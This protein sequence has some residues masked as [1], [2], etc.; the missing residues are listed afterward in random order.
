MGKSIQYTTIDRV[1]STIHRQLKGTEI[2]ESDAIEWVGDALD[3]LKVYNTSEEVVTF[4]EVKNFEIDIPEGFQM[5]LQVARNNDWTFEEKNNCVIPTTLETIETEEEEEETD[6]CSEEAYKPFFDMQ[7][8]YIPWTTSNCYKE[9]FTPIRLANH[10]FF[11]SIVCKER[12]YNDV[13]QNSEDEYTIVGTV[14]RKLRFSFQEGYVAL[15]YLRTPIDDITKL[16]LIPDSISYITAITYY[17]K[18]KMAEVLAWNGRDGFEGKADKAESKWLKYA[19]QG[20]NFMKMPKGLDEHQNHLERSHYLIP[21]H[22][23]YYGF[24]GEL[25]RKEDRGFNHPNRN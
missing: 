14:N 24:F 7:W 3:F 21:N 23:R 22:D 6:D 4:L 15:A 2:N 13:Y 8:Q 11:K 10:V 9:T 16:P 17:L 20:K 1:L 5:L 18:W 12:D 25:G 19:R